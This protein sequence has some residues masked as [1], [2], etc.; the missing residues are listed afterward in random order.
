M[1][2]PTCGTQFVFTILW[3]TVIGAAVNGAAHGRHGF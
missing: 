3:F 1:N 2:C